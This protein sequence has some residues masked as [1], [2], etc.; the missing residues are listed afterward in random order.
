MVK[1]LESLIPSIEQREGAWIQVQERLS[2]NVP[3]EFRTTLTLSREFGC[4]AY[5]LAECLQKEL[6]KATMEPWIIYAR[7]LVEK[8]ASDEHI[9]RHMLEHLG[10]ESQKAD[11]LK[12]E[13]GFPTHDEAFAQM[14]KYVLQIAKL[15]NAILVGRGAAAIC[16]DLANC[17]HIRLE[18]GLEWR[19]ANMAKRLEMPMEEAHTL[20]EKQSRLREQFVSNCLHCDITKAHWY[21]A[22]LNNER[23]NVNQMCAAIM[24]LATS[25]WGNQPPFK[26]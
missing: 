15:G 22:I 1:P 18:A 21:D 13:F 26:K 17:M 25:K 20:V 14:A 6:E 11:V 7:A 5:P 12:R 4:E 10:D 19:V 9:S 24:S 23:L 16:H 3:G 2:R 8:V